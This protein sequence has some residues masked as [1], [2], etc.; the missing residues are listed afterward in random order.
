MYSWLTS[1]GKKFTSLHCTVTHD[2]IAEVSGR[3]FQLFLHNL[4]AVSVIASCPTEAKAVLP[5]VHK[6]TLPLEKVQLQ[7]NNERQVQ[8]EGLCASWAH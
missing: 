6:G 4:F 5:A 2:S 7:T 8:G 3:Q 1:R